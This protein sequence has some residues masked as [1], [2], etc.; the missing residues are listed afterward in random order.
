MEEEI[1]RDRV[2]LEDTVNLLIAKNNSCGGVSGALIGLGVAER[3]PVNE[4]AV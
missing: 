3:T 4:N 1:V 2:A